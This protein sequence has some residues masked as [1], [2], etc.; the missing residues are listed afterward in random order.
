MHQNFVNLH[1]W[2]TQYLPL[3]IIKKHYVPN[4]S[5]CITTADNV[6][7]IFKTISYHGWD[8]TSCWT[9]TQVNKCATSSH[10]AR[11]PVLIAS[12]THC[13]TTCFQSRPHNSSAWTCIETSLWGIPLCIGFESFRPWNQTGSSS[14]SDVLQRSISTGN[15]GKLPQTW[16]D[17]RRA[18]IHH[19]WIWQTDP[20]IWLLTATKHLYWRNNYKL[21]ILFLRH[22]SYLL[23]DDQLDNIG[24]RWDV[25]ITSTLLLSRRHHVNK[26]HPRVAW[27]QG[28]KRSL[29][30]HIFSG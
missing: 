4:S 18:W 12:A 3:H 22:Q 14:G 6:L 24:R 13:G 16:K 26:R 27:S 1:T 20:L 17:S 25:L 7:G 10:T 29:H 9:M 5:V 21:I 2:Y 30:G 19:H 8:I 23:S 28:R 11:L 15:C